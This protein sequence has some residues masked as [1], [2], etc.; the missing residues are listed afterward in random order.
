MPDRPSWRDLLK[1][2][3]SEPGEQDRIAAAIG[4]RPITLTRWA[5]GESKPRPRNISQL[6]Q[7]L[8]HPQ[9]ER[10]AELL[11]EE[12]SDM[13]DSLP[14]NRLDEIEYKFIMQVLDIRASTSSSLLFWTL[15]R[16]VL[17]HALRLL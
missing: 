14:S 2:I 1:E 15:C 6:L 3:I 9:R 4:V 8:P 7:A 17:L 13:L 5:N 12:Y 11:E 10:L 16:K